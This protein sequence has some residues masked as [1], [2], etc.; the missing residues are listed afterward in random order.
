V[1]QTSTAEEEAAA[2]KIGAMVRGRKGR[3]VVQER[4]RDSIRAGAA[5]PDKADA[6]AET[7]GAMA[8]GRHDRHELETQGRAATVV[9]SR[10]RGRAARRS[11]GRLQAE[12]EV[13]RETGAATL[14]RSKSGSQVE[15]VNDY[16]F[17]K[18][19]GKGAYGQVWKVSRGAK[20]GDDVAA[21]KV[22]SR[23]ILRRKRV[24]RFGTA[25]DS[26]MGEIAVM[27]QLNHPNVVRLFEVI[28]DPD[29]DLLFMVMEIV[30]GGDLS[31][32]YEQKRR[33]PE[34]E[35]RVWL[36]GLFTGLEHLHLCGVCH[37]DI[38]PENMLWEPESGNVKLAD[39]GISGFFKAEEL[40]GD[41][42]QST[43]GSYPFFAPEMCRA[44]RGAGYSGRAADIWAC[45]VSLFMWMYHRCPYEADHIPGLMEA[46]A[47]DDVAWP[48]DSEHSPSLVALLKGLLDRRP[49][50]RL[51][52][53]EL[54]R[55]AFITDGG[56]DEMPPPV[57]VP[58]MQ[59]VPRTEL[60]NALKRV[61]LLQRGGDMGDAPAPSPAAA[62]AEEGADAAMSEE[63]LREMRSVAAEAA[64][65]AAEGS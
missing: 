7:I 22:L 29:E 32:P 31:K 52:I 65:E 35:L 57:A 42:I 19:L 53:K 62:S 40:G 59:S 14:K 56:M 34:P 50:M 54:R 48:D 24:G 12:R 46:I 9:Q 23:S 6:A 21:V 43:G 16:H 64:A 25:Y 36:R 26:V 55:D 38:K 49:K 51:R 33:V 41:F 13:V 11:V 44:L 15:K 39:F 2:T 1:K 28:D 63:A 45:G 4:R 47:N 17:G 61:L 37:R 58:P 18:Q 20:N 10:I 27:K 5:H 60:S 30:S 3:Q 8:R